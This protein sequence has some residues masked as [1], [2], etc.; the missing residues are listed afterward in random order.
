M[1]MQKVMW[2]LKFHL[3][4]PPETPETIK[5]GWRDRSKKVYNLEQNVTD[6]ETNVEKDCGKTLE[7]S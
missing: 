5:T 2:I 3:N 6:S 7:K 4:G 1:K